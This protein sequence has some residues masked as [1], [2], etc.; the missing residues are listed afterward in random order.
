MTATDQTEYSELRATIRERGTARVWVFTVGLIAWGCLSVAVVALGLPPVFAVVPLLVLAATFEAVYAL[1]IGVERIGR[2]L[3]VFH[4]AEG[5]GWEHAAIQLAPFP[6]IARLDPL[7]TAIF[8]AAAFV[9][10]FTVDLM[11]ATPQENV[12][13]GVAHGVFFVRVLRAKAF[14]ARQR[15]VD[16]ERFQQLLRKRDHEE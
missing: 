16:Q 15:S 3:H 13:V 2:Y 8:L 9:T 11:N 5:R 6:A 10:L 4:E 7:F 12:V 1:H 14:A